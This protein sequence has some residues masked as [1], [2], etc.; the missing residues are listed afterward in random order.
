[1]PGRATRSDVGR[2]ITVQS[3][4]DLE[5]IGTNGT[6]GTDL[7]EKAYEEALASE[8]VGDIQPQG[9]SDQ[10]SHCN[11]QDGEENAFRVYDHRT[12]GEIH[13]N[14]RDM[15]LEQGEED[16]PGFDSY[17]EVQA[18]AVLEG[19]VYGLFAAEEIRHPDGK[20]G[21][22]YEKGNLVAVAATDKY[23]DASF[24]VNTEAP[25]YVYDYEAG[26]IRKNENG[27]ADRSPKICIQKMKLWMTI[28]E[29]EGKYEVI[30]I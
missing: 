28:Q 23:G 13:I 4:D 20:T 3:G 27:F 21:I 15:M 9:P 26:K 11:N 30:S 1:M 14:K 5:D 29:I 10:Y 12:E 6:G 18:D 7:F 19:A 17:G 2:T 16:H 24:L 8:C 25:G 22:V